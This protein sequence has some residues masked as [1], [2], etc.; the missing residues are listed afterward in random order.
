[1]HQ[2]HDCHSPNPPSPPKPCPA[3]S[4]L[5]AASSPL[6]PS[7]TH[8][9]HPSQANPNSPALNPR[10]LWERGNCMEQSMEQLY[11]EVGEFGG[12]GLGFLLGRVER[13]EAGLLGVWP[14]VWGSRDSRRSEP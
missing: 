12:P 4:F 1:M 6:K 5:E 13:P 8:P 3:S 2:T 7:L 14:G 9:T 10:R 11:S